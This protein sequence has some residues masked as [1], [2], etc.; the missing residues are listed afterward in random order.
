MACNTDGLTVTTFG[1]AASAASLSYSSLYIRSASSAAYFS[2]SAIFS[3][4]D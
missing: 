1:L 4:Y 2:A 3:S